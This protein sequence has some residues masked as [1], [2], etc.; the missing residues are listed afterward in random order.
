MSE[1]IYAQYR[2][3]KKQT[4]NA[5]KREHLGITGNRIYILLYNNPLVFWPLRAFS[6]CIILLIYEDKNVHSLCL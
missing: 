6:N 5:P 1:D 4:C 2:L 3:K